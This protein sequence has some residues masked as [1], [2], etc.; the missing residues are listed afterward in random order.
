MNVWLIQIGEP[1]PIDDRVRKQRLSMLSEKLAERGHKVLRWGSAFDHIT[2]K[3]LHPGDFQFELMNNIKVQLIKGTGYKKNISFARIVDHLVISSKIL[4]MAN[5]ADK[6]DVILVAT[7]PHNIAFNVVKFANK[8]KIP[9]IVDVRDQWPDIFLNYLPKSL[10]KISRM[11]LFREFAIMKKTF[12]NATAITAAT[13][14]LIILLCMIILP[15]FDFIAGC[16]FD[17]SIAQFERGRST[18][19]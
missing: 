16:F 4:S 18:V 13:V 12:R 11:L 7:P 3:M 9:V 6:P 2:K 15:I 17:S 10:W 14:I 19:S 8:H 5:K 1:I